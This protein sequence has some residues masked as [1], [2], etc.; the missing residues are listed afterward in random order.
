MAVEYRAPRN[1]TE[2][3]DTFQCS[4][5]AFGGSLSFYL[6]AERWR[7]LEFGCIPGEDASLTGLFAD[8]FGQ[9]QA[10][11]AKE[12]RVGPGPLAFGRTFETLGCTVHRQEGSHPMAR[13]I[14]LASLLSKLTPLLA[15]RLCASDLSGWEGSIRLGYE[16]DERTLQIRRGEIA[17]LR[18]S[19]P[20]DIDLPLSQEQLLKLLFGNMRAEHIAFSNN[21]PLGNGDIALL[22][23]LFPR[24]E[25]FSWPTD[26]F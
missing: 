21:L 1:Q 14:N 20:P 11:E 26:G 2:L 3:E 24:D 4:D 6:M 18:S 7:L 12:V 9:A 16:A 23:A 17:V 19:S 10:G 8:L 5:A 15:S 25:L 13:I 22:E